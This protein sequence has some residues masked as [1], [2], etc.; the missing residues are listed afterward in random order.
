M[1]DTQKQIA[2][3]TAELQKKLDQLA[4]ERK[5]TVQKI[6]NEALALYA[7]PNEDF[8]QGCDW[9]KNPK[10]GDGRCLGA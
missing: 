5:T 8:C 3:Q 9:E 10:C 4:V 6:V 1:N 7:I 2:L